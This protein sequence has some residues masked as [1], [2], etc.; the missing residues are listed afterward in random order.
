M[1]D[2]I[3]IYKSLNIQTLI[4]LLPNKKALKGQQVYKTKVNK[5]GHIVKYKSRQVVKGFTQI[6]SIDYNQTFSNTARLET[7]RLLFALAIYYNW[8]I[9]QQDIILAF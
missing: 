6:Y 2:E 9:E 8:K 1:A 3:E 4:Q 5:Q 7:W